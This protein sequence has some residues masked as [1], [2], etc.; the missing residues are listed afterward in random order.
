MELLLEDPFPATDTRCVKTTKIA[1]VIGMLV[2]TL[3][4]FAY[5]VIQKII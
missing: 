1:I 2:V 5:A 4:V 3:F